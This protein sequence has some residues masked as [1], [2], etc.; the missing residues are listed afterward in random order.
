VFVYN[1]DRKFLAKYDGVMEAQRK[2][3]IS[4]TTI[5]KYAELAGMYNGYIFSYDIL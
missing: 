2:L 4:H 3:N 1:E 5:K